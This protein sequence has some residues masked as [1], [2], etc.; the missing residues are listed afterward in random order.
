MRHP[1]N[2]IVLGTFVS[3]FIYCLIVLGSIT[4]QKEQAFVPV[5]S[6]NFAILFVIAGVGILIYFIHHVSSSIQADQVIFSV[7]NELSSHLRRLF[8]NQIEFGNGQDSVGIESLNP[9]ERPYDRTQKIEHAQSGYLQ[10]VDSKGL[11]DIAKKN[12]ALFYLEYR[13]GE[14]VTI[15]SPIITA[16]CNERLN[17]NSVQKISNRFIIGSQ[18]TPEQDAEF[19]IYQLVEIAI[20]ALSPGINDPFTA[21]TCIDWLGSAICYLTNRTFPSSYHYDDQGKLRIIAKTITFS[22]IMNAA[23]DQIRQNS[24]SSVA[25]KIRLLET[26]KIIAE[27]I[28]NTEQSEAVFRQAE[29]II[30]RE[31]NADLIDNDF[32]D[33]KERY[34]A[35]SKAINSVEKAEQ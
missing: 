14:F 9:Q 5:F 34:D 12:D 1:G 24:Q 19:A 3:T 25:V 11:L 27:N 6:V 17:E 23:F 31:H 35:V 22:G 7:F 10:A 2:Q 15:G 33:L 28:R 32:Q 21:I 4:P 8:P 16:K 18:R 30:Q 13:P 26:L 29:M 20:R